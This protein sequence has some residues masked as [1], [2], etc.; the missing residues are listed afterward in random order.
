MM[1]VPERSWVQAP[2][3]PQQKLLPGLERSPC[4]PY[5]S[6]ASLKDT[7]FSSQC[8]KPRSSA[9]LH[10][11]LE[12]SWIP[13]IL[14][15]HAFNL[16]ASSLAL[17]S[18]WCP[19]QPAPLHLL[20]SPPY[21]WPASLLAGVSAVA[22]SPHF[23]PC[24]FLTFHTAAKAMEFNSDQSLLC[25]SLHLLPVAQVRT[26]NAP[27]LQCQASGATCCHHWLCQVIVLI[28]LSPSG[29]LHW[30]LPKYPQGPLFHFTQIRTHAHA[31][32]HTH[33]EAHK[34]TCTTH[35]S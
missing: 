15:T 14:H 24:L 34:H 31:D 35:T 29:C 13:F 17:L 9:Y 3:Q 19:V 23:K 18:E 8:V 28:L 25:Y 30:L 20:C 33:T 1:K 5:P 6:S 11:K 10:K 26:L 32:M 22:C 2:G 12:L 4:F 21:L 27:G 16:Q 7:P